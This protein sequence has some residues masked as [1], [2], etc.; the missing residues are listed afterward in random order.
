MGNPVYITQS[1]HAVWYFRW[2]LPKSL[3]PQG[4]PSDIKMSLETRDRREALR[5]ARS[6]GYLG[7]TL[8]AQGIVQGMRYEDL[9]ATLTKHFAQKLANKKAQIA[10]HGRL[11]PLTITALRNSEEA[12]QQALETGE[13]LCLAGTPDDEPLARFS[14]L[15]GLS[16]D[17]ASP[18]YR[19]F[20]DDFM[21]AFRD[22]CRAALAYD[23]SLDTFVLEPQAPA[24]PASAAPPAP[25]EEPGVP[26]SELTESFAQERVR[27]GNW[28][29]KTEGDRRAQLTLLLD[30]LGASTASTS[31]RAPQ[32]RQM[33]E[34]L[35]KLPKNRNKNPRSRGL[36]IADAVALPDDVE[37]M[38]VRT[39]N[40]H[41]TTY[42]ALFAWAKQN[43]LAQENP[44]EGLTIR[45]AKRKEAKDPFTL[46]QVQT[47]LH[48]LHTNERGLASK[49]YQRFGGLLGIYTGAR[50]NEIAQ[51]MLDDI[52]R[53]DASGIWYFDINDVGDE[54]NT[55]RL[56]NE[57]SKRRVPV[58]Q[59]LIEAGLLAHADQLRK[60]GER[61]LLH[62]LTFHKANGR[63]R[64]LSR[65][66]N[67]KLLV[68]LK[69]KTPK[70]SFHSYRHTVMN[71][72]ANADVPDPVI[73]D[74]VGHS[75]DSVTR[76][77]YVKGSSLEQLSA[78]IHKLPW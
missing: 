44:F 54:D 11:D 1:R 8:T 50:L 42:S 48:E 56:K 63:G 33:K 62:E 49:D 51:I 43:G 66:F 75:H 40:K 16:I 59:K 10:E 41:L 9:R 76:Q 61:F 26:L 36:T 30:V 74:L 4:R 34:I 24:V 73:K 71:F 2:P 53:D 77:V 5:L 14:A 67:E 13:T 3:H 68:E 69:L 78:A 12:A 70:L 57:A 7:E 47:I 52:K 46:A 28:T 17:P 35:S 23:R 32:A 15:Y 58:H 27:G 19:T 6:L 21:R 18:A 65:W 38:D 29:G 20:R 25:E 60:Q 37:R 55:K 72:L 22:Y 39:I 64:N 45:E 31:I